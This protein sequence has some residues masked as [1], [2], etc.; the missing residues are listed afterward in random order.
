MAR[1]LLSLILLPAIASQYGP[2]VMQSVIATRQAGLT[3]MSLPYVLPEAAGYVAT[4]DCGDI[5]KIV[6]LRRVG[7][8]WIDLL[9]CDCSGDAETTAWMNRNGIYGEVDYE[10]AV[11]WDTVG[12]GMAIE[13]LIGQRTGY[14]FR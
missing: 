11:M 4:R 14:A 9:V 10:T 8:P 6:R 1:V 12:H 2:G 7:G 3:A 13:V 5:G